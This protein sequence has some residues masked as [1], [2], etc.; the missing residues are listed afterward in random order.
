MVEEQYRTALIAK[1]AEVI[2]MWY[3]AVKT[4]TKDEWVGIKKESFKRKC[5]EEL[6]ILE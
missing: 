1:M 3:F 5:A 4:E 2:D 6:K